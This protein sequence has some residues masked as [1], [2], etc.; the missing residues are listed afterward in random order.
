MEKI[1][2]IANWFIE[3][4][5][6]DLKDK[7]NAGLKML[8]N[9]EP[10]KDSYKELFGFMLFSYS[11]AH[12]PTSFFDMEKLAKEISVLDEMKVYAEKWISHSKKTSV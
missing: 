10:L 11:M 5:A 6:P 7:I 12:G 4:K 8:E 3:V 2:K 1:T 9:K